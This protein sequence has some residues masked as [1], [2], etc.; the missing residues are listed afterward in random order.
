MDQ[1]ETDEMMNRF[2]FLM[3]LKM[4]YECLILS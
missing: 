4:Q 1:W 3:L 2:K